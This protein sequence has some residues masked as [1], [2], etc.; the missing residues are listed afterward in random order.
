MHVLVTG[1]TGFVGRALCRQLVAGGH[2]FSAVSRAP[3]GAM[4]SLDGCHAALS[5]EQLNA[6]GALDGVDAVVH[7]AGE[8]VSGRWSAAKRERVRQTRLGPTRSLV[9]AINRAQPRPHTLVSASGIGFYGEGGERELTEQAP[10]GDDYFADLCVEWEAA[11]STADTRVVLARFGIVLGLG[12]GAVASM[13]LPARLGLGGPLGSGRQWWSWV[14]LED[15]AAAI[16]HALL[17]ESL[18]GPV[19]VVAPSPVRQAD[20]AT[21]L[22]ACL[23]RPG[24]LP[25]PSVAIRLVLGTFAAEILASKRVL[26]KALSA[27]G[28]EYAHPELKAA[29]SDVVG[30]P[31]R[32]SFWL[33]LLASLTLGLAPFAPEPHLVGKARW[34]LGG[35]HGMGTNDWL[36]MLMHGAPW[37]WLAWSCTLLAGAAWTARRAA[38]VR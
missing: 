1:A 28:F 20:F 3:E 12:G 19:N 17:D 13:L 32:P 24:V 14:H 7:L 11:A 16:I 15:V 21:V 8:S 9:E 37:V 18:R 27:S 34:V 6:P 29:L 5:W 25:A 26:P 22:G 36:D 23:G 10:A 30:Q 2:R 33:P 35:A 38:T 31:S 4:Q